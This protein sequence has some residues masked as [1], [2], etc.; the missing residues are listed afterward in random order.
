MRADRAVSWL[1]R[2][3]TSQCYSVPVCIDCP[4]TAR[5]SAAVSLCVVTTQTQQV[6]ALQCPCVYWLPRHSTSQRCS[7]PVCSDYPDTARLS[8]AV[9]LCALTAHTQHVPALQF[10]CVSWLL[11]HSTSQR[12]SVPVC[13]D[14]PD[15]A[16]LIDMWCCQHISAT[17]D[18]VNTSQRDVTLTHRNADTLLQLSL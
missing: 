9:S 10:P 2:H 13:I 1:P 11:R 18:A 4:Y 3:S 12:C 6:S 5:L 17:C 14:C 8:A 7:V 15:T 16:H